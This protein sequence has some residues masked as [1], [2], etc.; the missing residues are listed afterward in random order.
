M[1]IVALAAAWTASLPGAPDRATR[2][3]RGY[4]TLLL[5][6]REAAAGRLSRVADALGP[7]VVS[8]LG[9]PVTFWD[10]T[11]IAS[12][13]YAQ[14]D[15]RIDPR[16]PR[17]DPYMDGLAGLFRAPGPGGEAWHVLYV[18]ARR[19]AP[20]DYLKV[21]AVLGSARGGWRLLEF[22]PLFTV[23]SVASLLVVAFLLARQNVRT[24]PARAAT[25]AA[26]V[27]LWVPYLLCGGVARLAVALLLFLS[28]FRSVDLLAAMKAWDERLVTE[29]RGALSFFLA[30][31]GGAFVVMIPAGG[32]HSGELIALAGP[33]AGSVLL[34]VALVLYQ[35][36]PPRRRRKFDPVPII[37][38]SVPGPAPVP[39][40]LLVSIGSLLVCALLALARGIPVPTPI[41]VPGVG[42]FSWDSLR[43]LSHATV[44]ARL[45]D[46]SDLVTHE[47]FQETL[48][49]GRTWGMPRQDERV[50][51]REFLIGPGTS[52]I[53]ATERRVKVFD[54]TWLASCFRDAPPGSITAMFL[55]QA[56][57]MAVGLRRGAGG[58][59]RDAVVALA[60]MAAMM[61]L[62]A[63]ETGRSPAPRRILALLMKSVV[64][65]FN[66]GARRNQTP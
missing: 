63:R 8:E 7:G 35:R 29:L 42:D 5:S 12:V 65:R 2:A 20:I 21:A 28:W 3:W 13:P 46:A 25:A 23:A 44:S 16:D 60:V 51:I 59:L 27:L 31:A 32:F 61:G 6:P 38:P 50:Y 45:P 54:S 37:R 52:S 36:R 66:G 11:G 14:L 26:A 64:V 53:I 22:D 18:P 1:L 58:A 24:D 34:A 17:H 4:D 10:F 43:R 19:P 41:G 57:P 48:A 47:S 62:L 39:A 56:R 55:A 15:G 9:A 33:V 49:F 40:A 30:L